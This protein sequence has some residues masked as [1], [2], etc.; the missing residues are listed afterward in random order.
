[1]QRSQIFVTFVEPVTTHQI[2]AGQPATSPVLRMFADDGGFSLD[3]LS[4]DSQSILL[5]TSPSSTLKWS[6]N[7]IVATA[8]LSSSATT[9]AT[10]NRKNVKIKRFEEKE[11]R[12]SEKVDS[13]LIS[14]RGRL[15][16]DQDPDV[17][18][19]AETFEN[20]I[21]V[22]P[23]VSKDRT[24]TKTVMPTNNLET[25]VVTKTVTISLS[26]SLTDSEIN[27]SGM[28]MNRPT[29]H[30][31]LSQGPDT[32]SSTLTFLLDEPINSIFPS[33]SSD[34]TEAT[35]TKAVNPNGSHVILG[36]RNVIEAANADQPVNSSETHADSAAQILHNIT[37]LLNLQ[38]YDNSSNP[39]AISEKFVYYLK[40]MASQ[41][42]NHRLVEALIEL[43]N[44]TKSL[45]Y[46][47]AKILNATDD[48]T[49]SYK[50]SEPA[51]SLLENRNA[52][53]ETV[54]SSTIEDPFFC[55]RP[56]VVY[57]IGM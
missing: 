25:K 35:K 49:N 30:T 42:T 52:G 20:E 55:R 41:S 36:L 57:P 40:N 29:R 33:K 44:V 1:M 56:D 45:Q 31:F 26:S 54:V 51:W 47:L 16:P 48:T 28:M 4:A 2:E 19:L 7:S 10:G 27:T 17:I 11:N 12:D 46:L 38:G 6:P 8:G 50:D 24:V 9:E 23:S 15:P 5:N 18:H 32:A 21:K 3:Y 22:T 43:N 53:Q 13:S 37:N 34:F 14:I 39:L